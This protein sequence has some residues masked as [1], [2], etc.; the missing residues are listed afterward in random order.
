M[1][2]KEMLINGKTEAE[3]RELLDLKAS[4]QTVEKCLEIAETKL[5]MLAKATAQIIMEQQMGKMGLDL[6]AVLRGK[7]PQIN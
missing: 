5:E 3:V 4:E 1:S 2:K 7:G 6:G